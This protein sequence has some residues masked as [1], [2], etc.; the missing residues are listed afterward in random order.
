V[1]P[2]ADE[3][4]DSLYPLVYDELRKLAHV[5]RSRQAPSD[6]LSTTAIVHEAYLRLADGAGARWKDRSHFFA[7][8]SRA[9]RFVLVDHARA[10]GAEKRGGGVHE[11]SLDEAMIPS[12][13]R[14][15]DLL[16]I[17]EALTRLEQHDARLGQLVQLRF[18]GGLSYEEVAEVVQLSVPTVKRDWARARV[19]LH[20]FMTEGAV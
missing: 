1:S 5:H 4:T 18:F 11:V 20:R 13:D 10:R 6:T 8:A 14:S 9:M 3:R 19:W 2:T 7:L 12:D 15:A 16:A 17:D